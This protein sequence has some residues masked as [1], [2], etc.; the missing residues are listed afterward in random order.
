MSS[1]D[2]LI[3]IALGVLALLA[4]AFLGALRSQDSVTSVEVLEVVPVDVTATITGTGRVRARRAVNVSS[5]V[6]GRIVQLHVKEGDEVVEGQELLRLDPEQAAAQASRAEAALEQARALVAQYQAELDQARAELARS[7]SLHERD[8]ISAQELEAAETQVSVR[9]SLLASAEAQ[10]AQSLASLSEA[11]KG[12]DMTTLR[13]PISGLVTALH[14]EEGETVVVGTMNNPGS[15]LLTISDM[16]AMEAVVAF[17]END[18]P[19]ISIGDSA[20]VRL[21]AFRGLELPGR[22][23]QIGYSPVQEAAR[24]G[25]VVEYEVLLTIE[26]APPGVRPG[27]SANAEVVVGVREQVPAVPVISVV[28]GTDADGE[29]V[30]GVFVERDG[31]AEWRPVELGMIGGDHAEILDGVQVGDRVIVGPYQELQWLRDGNRV[32]PNHRGL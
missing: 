19:R 27:L 22:V 12:L 20:L 10:L 2:K 24:P 6:M 18:V 26:D 14:V 29:P 1:K 17:P 21:D 32:I 3:A 8:L 16:D 4:V 23:S 13:A 11:S 30:E 31:V 25:G 5:D 7:R 9:H 15:L 28:M